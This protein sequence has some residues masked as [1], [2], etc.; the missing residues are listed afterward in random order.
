[1][2]RS[3][4]TS[5]AQAGPT[6]LVA[7]VDA[8][9]AATGFQAPLRDLPVLGVSVTGQSRL[10]VQT[11]WWESATLPGVHFAGTIEPGRAGL[12]RHGVPSNSGAVHGARYN[13]R[14]LAGRP[15]GWPSGSNRSG[16]T[17]VARRSPG[18]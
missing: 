5:D 10:P 3:R 13:G 12:R 6:W 1:M 4:S 9:V 16:R 11:S 18:S 15:V 14:V 8:V 17:S 2:A 7:E